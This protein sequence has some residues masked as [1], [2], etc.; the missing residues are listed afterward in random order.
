MKFRTEYRPLKSSL[1]LS[2]RKPLAAIGSCFT[3][4]IT[5]KMREALWEAVNPFGALYNPLSI[6]R[7]LRMALL[8]YFP[9]RDFDKTLFLAGSKYHSWILD[10]KFSAY[11]APDSIAKFA[12]QRLQLSDALSKGETLLV[13]FGTA[14]AYYL[15]ETDKW[16]VGNCHKQPAN[17][18]TRKR[19]TINE[20]TT[21]W[22]SLIAE[23]KKKIPAIQIIFTVSPVRHLKDG[24]EGNSRSKAILQIAVESLC[25]EF[26]CCYYFPAY[27][28]L[29]D[30]LRDYRFYTTDLVHPSDEAIEY[31]W[32]IFKDSY[33]D[34]EGKD[35]LSKG[36]KLSKALNHR[37]LPD[38]SILIPEKI[39]LEEES[40]LNSLEEELKKFKLDNRD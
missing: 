17:I 15:K 32:E 10:S 26:D 19:L 27:E 13:T 22:S 28:I 37:P 18:F 34:N 31:I 24:F 29:N 40:R 38:A 39:R 30:D 1:T 21:E 11:G 14:W 16:P 12:Q 3:E 6:A 25:N 2:P 4:N 33:L 7:V 20:I 9:D 8:S 36:L 35:I 23:L 5:T